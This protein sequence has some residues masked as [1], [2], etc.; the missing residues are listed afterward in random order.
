MKEK[1]ILLLLLVTTISF[2]QKL[3]KEMKISEDGTRLQLGGHPTKGFYNED[4]MP[5]IELTFPS[6]D[7]L[8]TLERSQEDI[9]ATMVVDGETYDSVGVRIKGLTSR[10]VVTKKFSLNITLDAFKEQNHKGYETLNLNNGLEDP[11]FVREILYNHVGR[12]Y[13]P[14]L[15]TNYAQL[16]VNGEYWGPY[17]NV[18]QLNGE[19]IREWFASNDGTRWR[20][21]SKAWREGPGSGPD[22][23]GGIIDTTFGGDIPIDGGDIPIDTIFGGDIPI[24]TVFGEPTDT[25]F[26]GEPIDTTNGDLFGAIFGAGM[27]TL[28]YLGEADSTY[29]DYYLLKKTKKENPWEDLRRG[30]EKLNTLPTD[31]NLYDNLKDY[32]DIDKALWF[33]A[34]ENIFMDSDGYITKGGMDYYVYWESET[35]RL[36]PLEYDGNSIMEIG[37]LQTDLSPFY[38]ENNENYPL[39]NRLLKTPELRQRYLA[40]YRNILEN[41]YTPAYIGMLIDGYA[42]KIRASLAMDNPKRVYTPEEFENDLI[43]L[44]NEIIARRDFLTNHSEINTTGLTINDVTTISQAP[45][46][47]E[48]VTISASISGDKSIEKVR[49]YYGEGIIGTFERLDMTGDGQGNFSATIPGFSAG[50]Y[51]R[52]YVEAIAGDDAKTAT[53]APKG[54]E[55]DVYVYRVKVGA[56]SEKTVVINEIMASNNTTTADQDGEYDDW[57]EL[58]NTTNQVIDLTGYFLSDNSQKLDKYDIPEGTIIPANGYLIVWA[59]EDGM[60]E[61]LH[62]NFKLSSS[63]EELFL[64][65][66]DTLIIDEI[67]FGQQTTDMALARAPNGT[68]DFELRPAT[69]KTNNDGEIPMSDINFRAVVINEIVA[70]NDS[71][72]MIVDV[73][74]EYDDWIELYNNTNTE[75]DLTGVYL[76]NGKTNLKK[77][78]FPKGTKISAKGYLIVWADDDVE[79]TGL[80]ANFKLKKSKDELTL[81]NTDGRIIDSLSFAAQITN[82]AYARVP[83]GT[84]AFQTTTSTFNENNDNISENENMEACSIPSEP[85]VV[86]GS[87]NSVIMEWVKI[88]EAKNYTIQIRFKGKDKWILTATVSRSKVMIYGPNNDFEYRIKANCEGEESVYSPIYEFSISDN[89]IAATSRS[90]DNGLEQIKIEEN[91][92]S[93]KIFPNPVFNLLNVTYQNK[94][95]NTKVSIYNNIGQRIYQQT[96]SKGIEV[97]SLSVN[98]LKAGCYLL[99]IEES[100]EKNYV[101]KFIKTSPF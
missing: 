30:T 14:S 67:T 69:F 9:L 75:I 72:S 68:G 23:D 59:D 58:F 26:G 45:I 36:V 79:Q 64:V 41:Y 15:K 57:I 82:I 51:V 91:S 66:A 48:S 61:G 38:Q 20:A 99:M 22:G 8:T 42:D 39:V 93:V 50:K 84:G 40:H 96:L 21:L 2:G 7:F 81:S 100:G 33:I 98:H 92:I 24:D 95:D 52:Y 86:Q 49:L 55:H 85:I 35:G 31:N 97:H 94:S 83:N 37:F 43:H 90:N 18:Q 4:K 60:Q 27:S 5:V 56:A 3:P 74:G 54:A 10:S 6:N 87:R 63:G 44:K 19:F 101:Q 88:E 80:H 32:L 25:F 89:L 13:G 12:N 46:S 17:T 77:W 62:A 73:D 28:N 16:Y 78:Q 71:T 76:S 29:Y 65:N 47:G 1:L 34:H 11:S 70:S 53:F